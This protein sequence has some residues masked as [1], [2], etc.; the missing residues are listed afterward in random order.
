LVAKKPTL[1]PAP[2]RY[3]PALITGEARQPQPG[4][5]GASLF[6]DANEVTIKNAYGTF[7]SNINEF[8]F[9][10]ENVILNLNNIGNILNNLKINMSSESTFNSC[11]TFKFMDDGITFNANIITTINNKIIILLLQCLLSNKYT[12]QNIFEMGTISMERK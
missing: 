7:S 1:A 5:T 4:I 6:I 8:K 3:S 9:H 2:V 10:E 12:K 11:M